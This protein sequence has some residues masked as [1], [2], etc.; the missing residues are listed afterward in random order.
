[1]SLK[2]PEMDVCAMI[3]E[4]GFPPQN[5][6]IKALAQSGMNLPDFS[7]LIGDE[8]NNSWL[9]MNLPDNSCPTGDKP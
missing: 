5:A 1:M 8:P 6:Q 4:W 7:Y 9:G 3:L 2:N